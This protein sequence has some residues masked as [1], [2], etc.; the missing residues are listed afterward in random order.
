MKLKKELN[1]VVSGERRD[2][3]PLLALHLEGAPELLQHRLDRLDGQWIVPIVHLK[4]D[5]FALVQVP[6]RVQRLAV[7]SSRHVPQVRKQVLHRRG[8][9]ERRA[10]R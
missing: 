8:L 5:P 7:W 10:S 4:K 6:R 2:R 1:L 3:T 9:D